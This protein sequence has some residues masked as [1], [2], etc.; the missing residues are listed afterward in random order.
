MPVNFQIKYKKT[1]TQA[2]QERYSQYADEYGFSD[3][4]LR[5]P[6]QRMIDSIEYV[7]RQYDKDSFELI[8]KIWWDFQ[9]RRNDFDIDSVVLEAFKRVLYYFD[10]DLSVIKED[11][12]RYDVNLPGNEIAYLVYISEM[13]NN[14]VNAVFK[15][16][17]DGNS[18]TG[19]R[20]GTVFTETSRQR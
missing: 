6:M 11:L 18:T 15:D 13:T 3:K 1:Y 7:M 10:K 19:P 17:I 20:R 9:N 14:V 4:Q 12:Q 5:L 8:Y 2:I 16:T